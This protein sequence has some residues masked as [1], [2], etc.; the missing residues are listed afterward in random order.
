MS[1]SARS[2]P[3]EWAAAKPPAPLKITNQQQ[4]LRDT[5]AEGFSLNRSQ[6]R[7]KG[8]DIFGTTPKFLHGE[9]ALD[10]AARGMTFARLLFALRKQALLV[11]HP[12]LYFA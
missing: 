9:P 1:R 6:R 7:S 4:A 11:N 10:N 12:V 5:V 3:A 8:A 2:S